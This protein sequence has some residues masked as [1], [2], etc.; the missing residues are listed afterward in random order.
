MGNGSSTATPQHVASNVGSPD[1]GDN[2]TTTNN[3]TTTT[4]GGFRLPL[5][6][7]ERDAFL[8]IE[9]IIDNGCTSLSTHKNISEQQQQQPPLLSVEPRLSTNG[10]HPLISPLN[11]NN[12]INHQVMESSNTPSVISSSDSSYSTLSTPQ[13]SPL[14]GGNVNN[15]SSR[16][17]RHQRSNSGLSLPVPLQGPVPKRRNS[18]TTSSIEGGIFDCVKV[19]PAAQHHPQ[20]QTVATT[21][22][23]Q[24][25]SQKPHIVNRATSSGS[26]TSLFETCIKPIVNYEEEENEYATYK[27]CY[28]EDASVENGSYY[29]SNHVRRASYQR[30]VSNNSTASSSHSHNSHYNTIKLPSAATT[31]KSSLVSAFSSTSLM[32][33]SFSPSPYYT[34]DEVNMM[35]GDEPTYHS[36]LTRVRNYHVVTTAAL[37]WFTGTAVNPLLRAGYLLRRNNELK[38]KN[39]KVGEG[40]GDGSVGSG[41]SPVDVDEAATTCSSSEEVSGKE[42]SVEDIS[43]SSTTLKFLPLNARPGVIREGSSMSI[44][45][46][47]VEEVVKTENNNKQCSNVKQQIGEVQQQSQSPPFEMDNFD[48]PERK[49]SHSPCSLD[50]SCFSLSEIGTATAVVAAN[51]AAGTVDGSRTDVVSPLGEEEDSLL[52][53]PLTPCEATLQL[54]LEPCQKEELQGHVTLVVPWL[55]DETDRILLYGTATVTDAKSGEEQ[56][57]PMFANQNEQEVYIRSWLAKEAG[58]PEEAKELKI[59]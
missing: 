4:G 2:T 34:E 15:G 12:N 47:D 37:P 49:L 48:D 59:L 14:S 19:Q 51:T 10:E 43:E 36:D 9:D 5:Y 30:S 45:V 40:E 23:V 22:N 31:S 24:L 32:S 35:D 42:D 53:S 28:N 39:N 29:S 33:A 55:T 58:M 21:N 16:L 7:G 56:V 3:I 44:D 11:D 25:L 13:I 54:K 8:P 18:Y 6:R 50:Y 52:L 41:Q 20:Q 27:Y 46:L 57:L 1:D 38:N 26:L 17:S